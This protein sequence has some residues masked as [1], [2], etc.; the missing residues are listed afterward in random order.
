M[1]I[2]P[3]PSL[4]PERSAYP[5]SVSCGF[6]SVIQLGGSY[7][8][9][10]D[11][12]THHNNHFL[13]VRLAELDGHLELSLVLAGLRETHLVG[14]AVG[15]DPEDR[16]GATVQGPVDAGGHAGV[17]ATGRNHRGPYGVFVPDARDDI[18][19]GRDGTVL[20]CQL[21]GII[22]QA[23]PEVEHTRVC[24]SGKG[25]EFGVLR[26]RCLLSIVSRKV[27][28][29]STIGEGNENI[30]V[31][32]LAGLLDNDMITLEVLGDD[33]VAGVDE[34][35]RKDGVRRLVHRR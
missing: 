15:M 6:G 35:C 18:A 9:R 16:A 19:D 21:A 5:L 8:S 32:R 34:R 1:T 17:G 10:H 30:P 27:H 7:I 31:L 23:N 11:L 33:A 13:L 22:A 24:L 14:F 20:L 28:A 3:K 26:R 29:G 12:A 25:V 4:R 2:L